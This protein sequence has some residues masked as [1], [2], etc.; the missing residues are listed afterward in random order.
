MTSNSIVVSYTGFKP[1]SAGNV[2]IITLIN[3]CLWS[4]GWCK[5]LSYLWNPGFDSCNMP[6][7]VL[8]R[9]KKKSAFT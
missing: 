3:E 8:A 2:E 9:S 1:L 4:S 5:G 6:F 7:R